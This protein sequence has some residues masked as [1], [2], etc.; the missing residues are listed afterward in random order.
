MHPTKRRTLLKSQDRLSAANAWTCREATGPEIL[1]VP[2]GY[3]LLAV[4]SALLLGIWK[5][6]L[7]LYRG[8]VSP[9]AVLLVSASAAGFAYLALGTWQGTL[10]FDV[11][12]APEGLLG[13]ALN[14][15]GTLLILKSFARGKVGVAVGVAATYVLVPLAYSFYLGE[16]LSMRAVI[17]V[18]VLMVGLGAFYAPTIRTR[19]LA[20]A[21]ATPVPI[22]MA[23]G[24]A[25]FWGAA[26]V[27]LNLGSRVSVTGTLATSQIPQVAIAGTVLVLSWDRSR[28]GLNPQAIAV[29]VGSGLALAL[30]NTAFF[31]AANEGN[32]GVVSVLG[33]LSPIV[34]ALLAAALLRERL[35]RTDR[36]AFAI[37]LLGTPWLNW[38]RCSA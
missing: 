36:I 10:A 6:G 18:A 34:T 1:E 24:A 21:T 27:V 2:L 9:Y 16:S 14:F 11:R 31:T 5:F 15:A 3:L 26:I 33:S 13:G 12:D 23:G 28:A 22:L 7:S 8:K 17:G 29:L 35:T 38:R 32:I 37:V 4:T 30:G 19:G 20:D 25:I